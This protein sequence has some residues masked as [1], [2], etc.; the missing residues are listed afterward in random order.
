MGQDQ[1]QRVRA[2]IITATPINYIT[3]SKFLLDEIARYD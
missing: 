1:E 2:H 3:E